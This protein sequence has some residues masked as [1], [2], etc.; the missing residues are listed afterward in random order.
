MEKRVKDRAKKRLMVKYGLDKADRT[1]FTKNVSH[2][3]QNM[4]DFQRTG[5]FMIAL[6]IEKFIGLSLFG[7][8]LTTFIASIKESKKAPGISELWLPGDKEI[9]IKSDCLANGVELP[10][11]IVGLLNDLADELEIDKLR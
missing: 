3:Y 5:H 8:R 1:A 6:N 10:A 2:L 9:R 7:T 4:E 11:K